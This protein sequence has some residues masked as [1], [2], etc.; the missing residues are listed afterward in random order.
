M[1]IEVQLLLVCCSSK[2]FRVSPTG[3]VSS[4]TKR[5]KGVFIWNRDN[6]PVLRHRNVS[7]APCFHT[8]VSYK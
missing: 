6:R 4:D 3:S 7:S 8:K 2:N 1:D 5:N